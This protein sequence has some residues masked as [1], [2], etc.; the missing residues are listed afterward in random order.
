VARNTAVPKKRD[1][2]PIDQFGEGSGALVA[3]GVTHF[4]K[5]EE[6]SDNRVAFLIDTFE[7]PAE[8]SAA[9]KKYEELASDE[10][11]QSEVD[12]RGHIRIGLRDAPD[13]SEDLRSEFLRAAGLSRDEAD[14]QWKALF[15][16]DG[17]FPYIDGKAC[18]IDHILELQLGGTNTIDNFQLLEQRANRRAGALIFGF[19]RR[20][21]G[22]IR[23]ALKG[24][25]IT[26]TFIILQFS[27]VEVVRR[28]AGGAPRPR[29]V[30]TSA[31]RPRRSSSRRPA[32]PPRS[33]RDRL[34]ARNTTGSLRVR[35]PGVSSSKGTRRSSTSNIQATRRP[36]TPR[37][38]SPNCG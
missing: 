14:R 16:K 31:R 2:T 6:S 1:W 11:L 12:I 13:A 30:G 4:A 19:I 24:L 28:V 33:P 26:P 21:A 34:R 27:K 17:T 36:G 35:L 15:P 9:E 5:P 10:L 18:D 29:A 25:T 22:Q 37:R 38:S 32:R 8:K 23:E 20:K 3:A 7:L